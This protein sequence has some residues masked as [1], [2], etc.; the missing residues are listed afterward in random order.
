MNETINANM[1]VLAR[2]ARSISQHEL[3]GRIRMSA[4]NLSKIERGNIGISEEVVEAIAGI[5]AYPKHFFW[6]QASVVPENLCYRKR[7]R[8][9]QKLLTS[10]NA[11]ANVIRQHA[12]FLSRGLQLLPPA[13]P[14]IEV[15]AHCPPARIAR[16]LRKVLELPS[17]PLHNLAAVLESRGIAIV[18]FD[19]GTPRVDS[20]SL[21]TDDGY[22]VI[23]LNL[24]LLGDRQRF[25][26]A[27]EL[28]QLVMH[29]RFP[30]ALD[31]DIAH[32]ANA[33]A[34][35]LLM[36]EK[37]MKQDFRNGLNLSLLGELKKKWKVSMISLLYRADDLGFITPNQKRYLLQQFNELRIRRREPVELDVAPEEPKLLRT[38]IRQYRS[39]YKLGVQEMAALLC[40]H[41]DEFLELYA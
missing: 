18:R 7:Q 31:R 32:E 33:F 27:Y 38:W 23:F 30:V 24:G 11:K 41:G 2:E 4:T 37:D 5:T 12:Q 1:I 40:L 10:I 28:G 25:S 20:K 34:A 29:T 13:L 19:F 22:P 3:A 35:E 39:R 14:T 26:L 16:R 6:Q 8:V 21:L 36:P 9:A 15:T 17:G